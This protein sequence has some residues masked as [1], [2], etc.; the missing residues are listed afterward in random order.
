MA[1][2]TAN[3]LQAVGDHFAARSLGWKLLAVSSFG[4]L[5]GMGIVIVGVIA[6]LG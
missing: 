4:H 6:A 3:W 1:G 2:A 5:P